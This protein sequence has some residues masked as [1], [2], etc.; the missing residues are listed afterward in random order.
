MKNEHKHSHY[1]IKIQG[2][3]DSRRRTWFDELTITFTEDGCTLLS[4]HIRDQAELHGVLRRISNLG[5]VLVS[6]NSAPKDLDG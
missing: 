4:G 5:L 3:L 2:Q 1:Q 6:V